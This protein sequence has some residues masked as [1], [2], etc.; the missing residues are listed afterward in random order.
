M[1]LSRLALAIALASPAAFAANET[2]RFDEQLKLPE[3]VVTAS[4]TAESKGDTYSAVT[5]FTR[6]DIER[7]QP[8]TVPDLLRRTPGV[9]VMQNGGRGSTVGVFVRGTKTAQTLV[10]ID[11]QRANDTNLGGAPLNTLSVDQIERVEILRGPRSAIYGSDAIGGVIQIF[12]RRAEGPGLSPRVRV[13]YGSH[14]TWE[15]SLG[16]SGGNNA[17]RFNLSL[18]HEQSNGFSRSSLSTGTDA[19]NDGFENSSIALNLN[20]RFSSQTEAGL[21][22]SHTD[23]EYEYDGFG[24]SQFPYDEVKNS[25]YSAY[26]SHQLTQLWSTRLE[27]GYSEG[28]MHNLDRAA[29]TDSFNE[30]ERESLNWTNSL[31]LSD[32]QRLQVGLDWY[33]DHI[34]NSGRYT[35]DSRY[36]AAAFLQHSYNGENFGT[37]VGVRHDD[38]QQFGT[39]NS[40]NAAFKL[41]LNERHQVTLSYAEGFRAPL[42]SDLY[43]PVNCYPGWGCSGGNPDLQPETSRT[44]E[45][46]WTGLVSPQ[47]DIEAAAYRTELEDAINGWPPA[48]LDEARIDGIE[49]TV[50]ADLLGWQNHLSLSLLNAEDRATGNDLVNRARKTLSWDIDRHFGQFA[51]GASWSASGRTYFDPAN[52]TVIPGYGLLGLRARW[53]AHPELEVAVKVDNLLDKAYY[54]T[55]NFGVPYQEDGR[56]AQLAFTWTPSL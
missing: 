26:L 28:E 45:L 31:S 33:R 36:N 55:T 27:L 22:I 14:D 41:P 52:T 3:V 2:P 49:V 8:S 9:Q 13:A 19:D 35:E 7:L 1:K 15:Q 17:T 43:Y 12:T 32:A 53:Q 34:H 24:W 29:V 50:S 47:V 5:V 16:L 30:T 11:G 18:N 37:E 6:D 44:Y 39:E 20:H 23:S 38:N 46:R 40:W 56:S 54:T 10:L 25:F 51:V 4:R 48:N 42:L 21:N